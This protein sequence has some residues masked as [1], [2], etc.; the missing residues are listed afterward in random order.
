[1]IQLVYIEDA[2]SLFYLELMKGN[3]IIEPRDYSVFSNFHSLIEN[4]TPFTEN[5]AGY[6]VKLLKKYKM[7][8]QL[9]GLDMY[10]ALLNPKWKQKFRKIDL[11]RE[12]FV[13]VEDGVPWICLKFPYTLKESFEKEIL[14]ESEGFFGRFFDDQ[15][16][17]K[18]RRL[19]KLNLYG[20]NLL[21]LQDFAEKNQFK[22]HESFIEAVNCTDDI[23]SRSNEITKRSKTINNEVTLINADQESFDFFQKNRINLE[24][25]LLLAKSM[26]Y[27]LEDPR[28]NVIEKIA[29]TDGN[30]FWHQNLKTLIQNLEKIEGKIVIILDRSSDFKKWIKN[31]KIVLAEIGVDS[32]VRV[33]FRQSNE[34]DKNFNQWITENGLGGKVD[35]GKYL[36]FLQK[37]NKW[38][39]NQP[40]DIKVIITNSI[41]PPNDQVAMYFLQSHPCVIFAG[42]IKP[43]DPRGRKIVNL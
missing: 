11:S 9:I 2:F 21:Q 29:A 1:M 38:L 39:F 3:I 41:Y 32:V 24:N 5:Q 7:Q 18:E 16:W 13:E 20:Y 37:P 34:Q 40:N 12:I 15:Y 36:I 10:E 6:A 4:K 26:G 28:E 8:W 23:W 33:C 17:D 42:D 35:Q 19:R 14:K 31:F 22:I 27:V 30:W 25:D 43:T